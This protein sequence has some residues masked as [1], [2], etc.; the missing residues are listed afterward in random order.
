MHKNIFSET[1]PSF[2]IYLTENTVYFIDRWNESLLMLHMWL[3]RCQ[4]QIYLESDM[5]HSWCKYP[6]NNGTSS[7]DS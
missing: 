5:I 4:E 6:V 2:C 3:P 1:S 7:D